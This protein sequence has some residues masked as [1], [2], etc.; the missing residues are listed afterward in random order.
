MAL[1]GALN[2]QGGEEVFYRRTPNQT[3]PLPPHPA[4]DMQTSHNQSRQ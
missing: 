4:H 2:L 3:R 1:Q